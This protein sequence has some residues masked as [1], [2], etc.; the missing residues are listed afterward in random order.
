MLFIPI[1]EIGQRQP[2]VQ[3]T[4]DFSA[5]RRAMTRLDGVVTPSR[6]G[7]QGEWVEMVVRSRR[8]QDGTWPMA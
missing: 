2:G 5:L 4:L 3:L 7:P 8:A 1:L 6:F